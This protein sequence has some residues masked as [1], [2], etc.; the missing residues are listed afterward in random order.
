MFPK[1][2]LFLYLQKTEYKM[3]SLEEK[4]AYLK[5]FVT[6]ERNQLF[7]KMIK[8][9]TSYVTLVL[10]D[11][12]QTHN[13]SAIVRS[14]DC[15]GIQNIHF[16]ENRNN[17]ILSDSISRGAHDWL[18][19][20][21]HQR[22]KNNSLETIK[23]L[24]A[25][26]YRI[27]A[28]TPHTDDVMLEDLDIT[29]GKMAFV[30]GTEWQGISPTIIEQADEY[31]RVPMYGFTESFNVSVCAA[32]V[33]YSVINK[34]RKSDINWHL[35]TQEELETFYRWYVTSIKSSKEILERFEQER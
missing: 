2:P 15:F 28:T 24:K 30:F 32:I 6:D 3:K 33:M 16:I 27:I 35:N 20:H 31:I 25:K 5:N 11:L 34:L 8:E 23:A 9:R 19:I 17:Y 7:E 18:S 10:E 12:F 1:H 21:Q 29:K 22:S 13:H 14:A 26:G 4:V